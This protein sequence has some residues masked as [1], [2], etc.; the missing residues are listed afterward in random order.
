MS[1]ECLTK[2]ANV[3]HSYLRYQIDIPI[4]LLVFTGFFQENEDGLEVWIQFKLERLLD[5]LYKC[6]LFT[7]VIGRYSFLEPTRVRMSNSILARL[8]GPWL[9][10][11][12]KETILFVNPLESHCRL[13]LHNEGELAKGAIS[14]TEGRLQAAD[15]FGE[16]TG[17]EIVVLK[18]TTNT[19]MQGQRSRFSK[20]DSLACF[21]NAVEMVPNLEAL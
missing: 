5:F 13:E 10:V 14:K 2:H 17:S 4:D 18:P 6:G 8:Y 12:N 3:N 15:C 11:E 1:C 19:Q 9:R 20:D 16:S 7:Y 21:K